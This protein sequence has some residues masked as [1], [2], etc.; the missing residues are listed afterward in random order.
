[1]DPLSSHDANASGTLA[2]LTAAKDTNV[3][4]VVMASS[5][6]VYGDT[7]TLPKHEKMVPNPQSPYAVTKLCSEHYAEV[8]QKI[9]G[10]DTVS[11]R[12]FNVY[13]PRQDPLS[14]YAAVIPRFINRLIHGLSP[15]IHGDGSQTRDFTYVEDVVNANIKAMQSSATGIFNIAGGKQVSILT[16]L[17]KISS[18]IGI[19]IEPTFLPSRPGDIHD[20]FADVSKARNSFGYTPEFTLEE[21]ISNIIKSL[22]RDHEIH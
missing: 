2:V 19:H 16:L 15:E 22:G 11:L 4:K 21:G 7:P 5:S 6:S 10:L 13:G 18:T 8:F 3:P 17:E 12:Y 9:F 1:M 20:S 14:P